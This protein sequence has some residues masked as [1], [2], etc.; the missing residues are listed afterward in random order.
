MALPGKKKA[1]GM[2]QGQ[3]MESFVLLSAL[4]K[5][6]IEDMEK[7]R[8]DRGLDSMLGYQMPVALSTR[9]RS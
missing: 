5:E 8:Q 9:Q 3:M 1:K 4:G 7:L 2:S 6:C